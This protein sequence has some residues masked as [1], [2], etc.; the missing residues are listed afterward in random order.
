MKSWYHFHLKFID[1]SYKPLQAVSSWL[2]LCIYIYKYESYESR[3]SCIIFIIATSTSMM[4]LRWNY[5]LL[6]YSRMMSSHLFSNIMPSDAITGKITPSPPG[7]CTWLQISVH[8]PPRM[9]IH[10]TYRTRLV[11]PI[12]WINLANQRPTWSR[13]SITIQ[14]HLFQAMNLL[15]PNPLAPNN[16]VQDLLQN[17]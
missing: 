6:A 3:V 17:P 1:L 5:F 11:I 2:V 15:K 7:Q 8:N 14:N 9:K 12:S 13:M 4:A 16:A 10:L